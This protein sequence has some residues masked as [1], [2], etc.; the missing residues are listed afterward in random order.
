MGNGTLSHL[1]CIHSSTEHTLRS[2]GLGLV[3]EL[4]PTNQKSLV[5]S[6]TGTMY[7]SPYEIDG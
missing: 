4:D 6:D 7:H 1:L 3:G 5:L 2:V